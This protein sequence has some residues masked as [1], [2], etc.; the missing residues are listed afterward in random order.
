[1]TRGICGRLALF[2]IGWQIIHSVCL[3]KTNKLIIL[4]SYPTPTLFTLDLFIDSLFYK[5]TSGYGSLKLLFVTYL[6]WWSLEMCNV[7]N[8]TVF[9]P[10]AS[11]E[12][13]GC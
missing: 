13:C 4:K 2:F 12:Y 11:Y 8:C 7:F 1:M 3:K 5:I 6:S 9:L 10:T